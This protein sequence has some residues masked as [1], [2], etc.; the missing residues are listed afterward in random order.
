MNKDPTEISEIEISA[1][2]ILLRNI[3]KE[4]PVSE[5]KEKL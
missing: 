3:N 4:L 1:H 5:V 2:T